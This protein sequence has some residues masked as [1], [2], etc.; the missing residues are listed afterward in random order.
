MLRTLIITVGL[1][2]AL[3]AAA[4]DCPD[5]TQSGMNKCAADAYKQAD[6]ALNATY[7]Q[8]IERLKDDADT[9]KSLVAAQRAWI[10]YRDAECDFITSGAAGGT[11]R[12]MLQTMCLEQVTSRRVDELKP[13]LECEEGDLS[14]P[15]PAP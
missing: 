3:P 8:I 13:L 7:K 1:L 5:E 6:A 11:V 10:A 15:V 2:A 12:R 4:Q 9:T 14:C